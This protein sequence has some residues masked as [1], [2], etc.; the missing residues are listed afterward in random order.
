MAGLGG[1]VQAS[2]PPWGGGGVVSI[3]CQGM[4]DHKGTNVPR[5][6]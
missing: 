1:H 3:P 2:T 5:E 6:D 4:S